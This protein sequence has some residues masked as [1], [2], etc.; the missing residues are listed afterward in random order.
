MGVYLRAPAEPE[1][2]LRDTIRAHPSE[3][4][5]LT[6]GPLTNIGLLFA[7]DPAIPAL[8]K[9]LMMM[10]GCFSA[11]NP[12]EEWNIVC[13]PHPAAKYPR[14]GVRGNQRGGRGERWPLRCS[15]CTDAQEKC[16]KRWDKIAFEFPL[17]A[18]RVDRVYSACYI[19]RHCS[20]V[21]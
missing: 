6:I 5:L 18:N 7:L 2:F 9:D 12:D 3:I 4:T 19:R 1:E 16:A 8:L 21:A 20:T 11:K 13:D 15:A 17:H 10:G 14:A